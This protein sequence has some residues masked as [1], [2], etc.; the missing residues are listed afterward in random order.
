MGRNKSKCG[1]RTFGIAVVPPTALSY[2]AGECA[3]TAPLVVIWA[4]RT[5]PSGRAANRTCSRRQRAKQGEAR[6][7][8]EASDA[9]ERK[10]C[11]S[12][13]NGCGWRVAASAREKR[14]ASEREV[15]ARRLRVEE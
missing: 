2:K 7:E 1:N 13:Q 6:S 4:G 12:N 9:R 11:G 14:A 10:P 5:H 8:G 15:A 3:A